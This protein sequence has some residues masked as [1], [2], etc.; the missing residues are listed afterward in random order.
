M[1]AVE[2]TLIPLGFKAPEFELIDTISGKKVS[3]SQLKGEKATV[4]MFICNHC[5]YVVHVR[6]ELIKMANEYIPKG[7]AF[8]A[9]SSNDVSRYPDDS[10]EKMK[11]LATELHF[12][13]PY[14]YDESQ[15]VAKLY[16]AACTPDFSIFDKDLLCIYRGQLDAARPG[17][18]K[19]VTGIDIRN[20]LDAVINGDKINLN[21]IPSI[22][23][24]IKWKSSVI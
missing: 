23:C 8:I 12:P 20:V 16:F 3:L 17:N 14:L 6:E 4:F 5:P 2:T 7:I 10:P 24:S 19:P 18:G 21:Q 22:G 9:I 11:S 13:F 15:E 1:A